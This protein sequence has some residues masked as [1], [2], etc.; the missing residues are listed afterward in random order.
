MHQSSICYW[1]YLICESNE[2]DRILLMTLANVWYHLLTIDLWTP[3]FLTASLVKFMSWKHATPKARSIYNDV[4]YYSILHTRDPPGQHQMIEKRF[5]IMT[6]FCYMSSR[7]MPI[8]YSVWKTYQ[9]FN[10]WL[11]VYLWNQS[12]AHSKYYIFDNNN[13]WKNDNYRQSDL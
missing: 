7:I 8:A 4:T 12:H 6:Q 3:S 13:S 2:A 5:F 11:H 1:S 9:N 10:D